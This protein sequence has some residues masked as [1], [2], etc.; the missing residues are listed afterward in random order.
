MF[1]SK[2]VSKSS[3]VAKPRRLDEGS[4]VRTAADSPLK[5]S[6]TRWVVGHTIEDDVSHT[7]LSLMA[8]D[9]S[10]STP[11]LAINYPCADLSDW[12]H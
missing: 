10:G 7:L 9:E 2:S 3:K 5:Q 11:L 1:L 6:T 4:Y 12:L 8:G